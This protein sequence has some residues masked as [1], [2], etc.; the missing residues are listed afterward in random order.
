MKNNLA[1]EDRKRVATLL[2]DLK[3]WRQ[4][5]VAQMMTSNLADDPDSVGRRRKAGKKKM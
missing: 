5:C 1:A 4:L 2:K 3:A